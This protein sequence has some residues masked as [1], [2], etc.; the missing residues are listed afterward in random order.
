MVLKSGK[1]LFRSDK[2]KDSSRFA[3]QAVQQ[4]LLQQN[5]KSLEGLIMVPRLRN[6]TQGLRRRF[7][8]VV[9]LYG[10]ASG[11]VSGPITGLAAASSRRKVTIFGRCTSGPCGGCKGESART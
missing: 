10:S 5:S 3:V 6:A 7:E 9:N 11:L 1:R 8:A 4:I 2:V